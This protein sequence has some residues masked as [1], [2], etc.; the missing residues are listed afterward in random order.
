MTSLLT[1]LQ[2]LFHRAPD[3]GHKQL[4]GAEQYLCSRIRQ[5]SRRT[6]QVFLLSRVDALPYPTI[7]QRLDISLE[8]L[9]KD[10]V[11]ALQQTRTPAE[12]APAEVHACE[13]YVKLQNPQTTASERIDFRRWLD[14]APE[15]LAAF[16]ETEL[17]WRRLLAPARHLALRGRYRQRHHPLEIG[18]WLAGLL[19]MALLMVLAF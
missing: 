1:P 15:H 4:S 16:H 17:H 19:S 8:E 10:M 2:Q 9:H 5:L 18:A 13:W 3:N 11:R 7:A 6:Q 12:L 14:A